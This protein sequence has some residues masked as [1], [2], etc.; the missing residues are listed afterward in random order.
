LKI[1]LGDLFFLVFLGLLL[2]KKSASLIIFIFILLKSVPLGKNCLISPFVFSFIPLSHEE[3]GLQKRVFPHCLN[4]DIVS[5]QFLVFR[6]IDSQTNFNRSENQEL[7][8][9]I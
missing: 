3:Y 5:L 4:A 1:S 6:L 2:I 9:L 7:H 8:L